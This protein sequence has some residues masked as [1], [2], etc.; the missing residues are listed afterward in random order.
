MR[1]LSNYFSVFLLAMFFMIGSINAQDIKLSNGYYFH[2]E[3]ILPSVEAEFPEDAAT[4]QAAFKDFME[5]THIVNLETANLG[6]QGR[7]LFAEDVVVPTLDNRKID[8][9]ISVKDKYKSEGSTMHFAVKQ[10]DENYVDRWYDR[11]TYND[12]RNIVLGFIHNHYPSYYKEEISSSQETIADLSDNAEMIESEIK[13]TRSEIDERYNQ[14]R[15]LSRK[16]VNM[17]KQMQ[18]LEME[19]KKELNQLE[20]EQDTYLE[21]K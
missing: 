12:M 21:I 5:P 17:R 3:L 8:M 11:D 1:K 20:Y 10:H 4:V 19:I 13:E 7:Y 18:S 16:L 6:K 14:I 2:E 9:F 15:V